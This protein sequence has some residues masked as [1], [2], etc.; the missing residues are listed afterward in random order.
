MKT[1]TLLQLF[2]IVDGRLSTTMDDVYDILNTAFDT[3]FMTHHLPTAMDYLK[4][5]KPDWFLKAEFKL[6]E[7]RSE[8]GTDEFTVLIDEICRNYTKT[9]YEVDKLPDEVLKGFGSYLL[10]NSL[11]LKKFSYYEN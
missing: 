3:Q 7:I 4:L 9:E 8:I 6:F 5:H 2:S 10:E 1:F 11:L